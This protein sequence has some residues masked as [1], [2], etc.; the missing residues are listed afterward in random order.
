M[1][2]HGVKKYD[3]NKKKNGTCINHDHWSGEKKYTY[4]YL[5][6]DHNAKKTRTF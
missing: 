5:N 2:K 6:G 3:Y 4:N 1:A